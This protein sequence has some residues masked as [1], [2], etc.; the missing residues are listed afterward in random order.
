MTEKNSNR[1]SLVIAIL[2]ILLILGGVFLLNESFNSST[3]QTSA[4]SSLKQQV[5]VSKTTKDSDTKTDSDQ[6]PIA[7]T[8]QTEN[9]D[10]D[11]S[12]TNTNKQTGDTA[13][14]T[15]VAPKEETSQPATTKP[16]EPPAP[17]PQQTT[18]TPAP[19]P[20]EEPKAPEAQPVQ[21]QTTNRPATLKVDQFTAKI[22]GVSGNRYTINLTG[23]G[24]KNALYCKPGTVLTLYSLNNFAKDTVEGGNEYLFTGNFSEDNKGLFI[25]TLSSMERI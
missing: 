14:S 25:G 22:T 1:L 19:A 24:L 16:V 17:T 6:S 20:K 12:T 11:T 7:G 15:K 23:C 4:K 18:P 10:Q 8:F 13:T 5:K 3:E 9:D 2:A 21:T